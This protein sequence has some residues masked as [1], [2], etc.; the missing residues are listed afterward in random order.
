MSNYCHFFC[1]TFV[2]L[3]IQKICAKVNN[4]T[5]SSFS[6]KVG[7]GRDGSEEY[8]H[9]NRKERAAVFSR[10]QLLLSEF[11]IIETIGTYMPVSH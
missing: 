10:T 11:V 1:S 5:Q 4:Y 9:Q 6:W 7:A 8:T 2:V 3:F